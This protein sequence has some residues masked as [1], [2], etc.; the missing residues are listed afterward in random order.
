MA[1]RGADR[2]GFC[3]TGG[4]P[5]CTTSLRSQGR[6]PGAG[7]PQ[8]CPRPAQ[9]AESGKSGHVHIRTRKHKGQ[10]HCPPAR[11]PH[12]SRAFCFLCSVASVS[13][14]SKATGCLERGLRG[15]VL[16]TLALAGA[17][18]THTHGPRRGGLMMGADRARAPGLRLD[19]LANQTP[20]G[21]WA[22]LGRVFI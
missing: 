15:F 12:V 7:R 14:F 1:G 13:R 10:W 18:R 8:D 11:G 4:L 22:A 2:M 21:S 17:A 16:L 6:G 20:E 5:S 19:A 3:A 9:L